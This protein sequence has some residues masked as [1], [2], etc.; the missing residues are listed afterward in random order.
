MTFKSG[1][2]RD[3]A[4]TPAVV[5]YVVD[6][7]T[8]FYRPMWRTPLAEKRQCSCQAVAV[9]TRSSMS[10]Y[11][12]EPTVSSDRTIRNESLHAIR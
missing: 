11:G 4:T 7:R 5:E 2:F 6:E 9:V 8:G 12:L 1:E 10:R 3:Q